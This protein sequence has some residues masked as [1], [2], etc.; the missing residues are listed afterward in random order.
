MK[1]AIIAIHMWVLD[2]GI[3][4]T[5]VYKVK[6]Y[7]ITGFKDVILDDKCGNQLLQENNIKKNA[8]NNYF[9]IWGRHQEKKT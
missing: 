2:V 4:C 5:S 7:L 3:K 9:G 8:N 6:L 1:N